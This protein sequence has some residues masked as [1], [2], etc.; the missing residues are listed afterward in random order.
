MCRQSGE[1]ALPEQHAGEVGQTEQKA[2]LL[3][4]FKVWFFKMSVKRWVEALV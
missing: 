3:T 2:L 1:L 4:D